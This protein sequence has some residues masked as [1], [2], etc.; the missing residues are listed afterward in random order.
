MAMNEKA[1]KND[2][3][4]RIKKAVLDA[5]LGHPRNGIVAINLPDGRIECDDLEVIELKAGDTTIPG[6]RVREKTGRWFSI[7]L[8][9]LISSIPFAVDGDDVL[10]PD[11]FTLVSKNSKLMIKV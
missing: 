1:E 5:A 9:S 6:F 2:G 7:Y 10:I 8:F 4:K 11:Q 3:S